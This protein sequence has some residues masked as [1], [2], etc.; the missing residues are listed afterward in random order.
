MLLLRWRRREAKAEAEA[1]GWSK[2]NKNPTWQCGEKRQVAL[3][4]ELTDLGVRSY[5]IKYNVQ[6]DLRNEINEI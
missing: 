4:K 6:I 1:A 5:T 2:K 3:F